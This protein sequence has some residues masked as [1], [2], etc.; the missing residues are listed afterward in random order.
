MDNIFPFL[1]K[2][3]IFGWMLD[4]V[5]LQFFIYILLSSSVMCNTDFDS[6][7]YLQNC[8]MI[9]LIKTLKKKI[10]FAHFWSV[11]PFRM[12]TFKLGK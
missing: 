11:S 3:S 10:S 12:G 5:A 7:N 8:R 1:R 6:E 4:I 9:A 2:F